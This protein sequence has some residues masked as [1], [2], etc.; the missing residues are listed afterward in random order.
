MPFK[1][2]SKLIVV[3]IFTLG[4]GLILLWDLERREEQRK[5]EYIKQKLKKYEWILSLT[6]VDH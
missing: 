3:G 4:L 5:E 6:K 2:V 1:G